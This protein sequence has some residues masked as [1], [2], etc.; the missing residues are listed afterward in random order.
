MMSKTH[1]AVAVAASLAVMQPTSSVGCLAAVA[2]GA[3]GGNLPDI[4]IRS[5]SHCR[6]ALYG[7]IIAGTIAVSA[8][9]ADYL[10]DG[11]VCAYV[12]EHFGVTTVAGAVALIAL[13]AI[14]AL[15]GHRTFSHS[16]LGLA[17]FSAAVWAVCPALAAPFAIGFASHLALDL[18]NKQKLQL[19]FPLKAGSFC[20]GLCHADGAAN[21]ALMAIGTVATVGLFAWKFAINLGI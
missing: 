11:G 6:D 7:R 19:F 9:A 16:L 15:S 4:D 20:L 12:I 3:V 14:G 17:L 1:I 2:G 21:T 10:H 5:N 8:L 18:L 13:C